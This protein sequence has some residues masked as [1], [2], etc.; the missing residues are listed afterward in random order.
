MDQLVLDTFKRLF[1]F[2]VSPWCEANRLRRQNISYSSVVDMTSQLV[3]IKGKCSPVWKH[4]LTKPGDDTTVKC[5]YC[6]AKFSMK[7]PSTSPLLYHLEKIEKISIKKEEEATEGEKA[8]KIKQLTVLSWLKKDSG[9]AEDVLA[10]L[11]ILDKISF[12][13]LEKSEGIQRGWRAEGLQIPAT[14]KNM[15]KMFLDHVG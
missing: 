12:Y 3:E 9:S 10:K 8:K 5:R 7:N 4:F 1:S 15:R 13:R 14:R 11:V 6:S 2:A